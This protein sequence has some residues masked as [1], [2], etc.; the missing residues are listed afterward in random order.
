MF[1][2]GIDSVLLSAVLHLVLENPNSQIDLINVTFYDDD[3][4]VTPS[5][6]RLASIAAHAELIKL[7]PQRTFNLVHIDISSSERISAESHIKELIFPS[8]THMDLNIGTAFWFASRGKGN[9]FQASAHH[10]DVY[11]VKCAGR[12]L[13]RLGGKGFSESVGLKTEPETLECSSG[14][15]GCTNPGCRLKSKSTCYF[16]LCKKCCLVRQ[17]ADNCRCSAHKLA[18][19]VESTEIGHVGFGLEEVSRIP[20]ESCCRVLLNGIGAD[21]QLAGYGR[22]RT[23]FLRGGNHALQSELNMDMCR[24]WQRNLGR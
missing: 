16:H 1:S 23:T 17:V 21:E 2:G 7:F 3:K 13:L 4:D 18:E 20:F 15:L 19:S 24:L 22:H 5:P 8:N 10:E 6:D 11:D 14:T 12:P 9:L